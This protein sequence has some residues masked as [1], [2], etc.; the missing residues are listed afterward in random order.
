MSRGGYIFIALINLTAGLCN[1]T[2]GALWS[3]PLLGGIGAFNFVCFMVCIHLATE[4]E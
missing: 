3:L 4:D 2:V 1:L